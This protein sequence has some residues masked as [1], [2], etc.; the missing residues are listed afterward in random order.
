M[1]CNALLCSSAGSLVSRK[2]AVCI[3]ICS[4]AYRRT[5]PRKGCATHFQVKISDLGATT[6]QYYPDVGTSMYAVPYRRRIANCA[7][8]TRPSLDSE[9]IALSHTSSRVERLFHS[10]TWMVCLRCRRPLSPPIPST[11]DCCVATNAPSGSIVCE[12]P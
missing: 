7:C 4:V 9:P 6:E 12:L 2:I 3:A 5:T 11:T 10:G 1:G 8:F